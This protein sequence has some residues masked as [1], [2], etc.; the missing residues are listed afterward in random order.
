MTG[1]H[2][3]AP[4]GRTQPRRTRCNAGNVVGVALHQLIVRGQRTRLGVQAQ[5]GHQHTTLGRG[6]DQVI[7]LSSGGKQCAL[8]RA[9]RQHKRR[10]HPMR[11]TPQRRASGPCPALEPFQQFQHQSFRHK[12]LHQEKWLARGTA[13]A[14]QRPGLDQLAPSRRGCRGHSGRAGKLPQP[15]GRA[16]H[17]Q[18]AL[19]QAP[20]STAQRSACD[21]S[22]CYGF[23]SYLRLLRKGLSWFWLQ[24]LA[25]NFDALAHANTQHTVCNS[26]RQLV[27][28]LFDSLI[29]DAHRLGSGGHITTQ[30]FNG[31][32]LQHD[33]IKP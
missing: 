18:S 7:Q 32:G 27:R 9:A 10:R 4:P 3:T 24:K 17:Q 14:Q 19:N 2:H 1:R 31:F 11:P 33:R 15:T 8:F 23:S 22:V 6:A 28:P 25:R 13:A 5:L 12:N 16:D 30:Q 21:G 20:G 29:R 26:W